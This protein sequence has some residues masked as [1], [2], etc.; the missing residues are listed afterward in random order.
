MNLFEMQTDYRNI[1]KFSRDIL[2][3]TIKDNI[4]DTYVNYI[5]FFDKNYSNE[6]LNHADEDCLKKMPQS[7]L[8]KSKN[9]ILENG[10]YC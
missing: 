4:C 2:H 9:F 10:F 1:K 5:I 3:Q 7:T 8:V 6:S